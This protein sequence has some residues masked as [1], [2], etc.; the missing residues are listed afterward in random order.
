MS[1]FRKLWGVKTRAEKA[2]DLDRMSLALHGKTSTRHCDLVRVEY[3][4]GQQEFAV[5][6]PTRKRITFSERRK[7]EQFI[8]KHYQEVRERIDAG[9]HE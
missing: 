5:T 2:E 9:C 1:I 8:S 4:G 7:C 6:F 3:D